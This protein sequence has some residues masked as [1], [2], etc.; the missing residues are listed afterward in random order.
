MTG[1]RLL[2]VSERWVKLLLAL[3]PGRFRE[4]VG[5][6]VMEAYRDR[7]RAAL[8]DGG[9]PALALVWLRAGIDSLRNGPSEMVSPRRGSAASSRNA[10]IGRAAAHGIAR[11]SRTPWGTPAGLRPRGIGSRTPIRDLRTRTD[12]IR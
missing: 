11:C 4:E 12:T 9:T 1:Q 3:Y 5:A 10:E 7:C 6:Q 8:E 2:A